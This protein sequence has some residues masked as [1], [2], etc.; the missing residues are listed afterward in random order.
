MNQAH[1]KQLAAYKQRYLDH[2][3]K[4]LE[5][6]GDDVRALWN[7]AASQ[8]A[9]F[10]VL[11]QVGGLSGKAVLDVGCGFG[12]LIAFLDQKG[13]GV[14]AYSGIDL[15]PEMIAIAREKHPR[16]Q[17]ECRDLL[18]QPFDPES[19]DVV[20]GSGLFFLPHPLWDAYVA[21][22]VGSMFACCR[23]AVAVNFLSAH[24]SKKDPESYYAAPHEVLEKLQ[25]AITPRV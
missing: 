1:A 23:Q 9:R 10:D 20:L 16:A 17:F 18:E 8:M 13:I 12:D 25:L 6:Y 19:F 15:S 3:R 7:S 22:Y 11:L 2:F 21:A 4:R 14:A 24:S 5:T